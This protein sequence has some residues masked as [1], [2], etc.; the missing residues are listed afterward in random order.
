MANVPSAIPPRIDYPNPSVA[1]GDLLLWLTRLARAVNAIPTA[2]SYTSFSGGPNSNLTGTPGDLCMNVIGAS[3]QT[4]RL[5]IKDVGSG[6]T[7]WVSFS[8]IP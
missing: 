6:N 2:F 7:G 5:F 3:T 8:T 1:S 4:K